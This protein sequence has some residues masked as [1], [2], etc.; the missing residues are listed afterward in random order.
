MKSQI[1]IAL[2]IVPMLLS[3]TTAFNQIPSPASAYTTTKNMDKKNKTPVSTFCTGRFLIDLPAGSQLSGGNYQYAFARIEVPKTMSKDDF[4][5]EILSREIYLR[6]TKHDSGAPML[7]EITRPDNSSAILVSWNH[8]ASTVVMSIT[9]YRWVEGRSFFFTME[10]DDDHHSEGLDAMRQLLLNLRPRFND[11]IPT[12]PGYCFEGGF[13]ANPEWENEEAGIDIDI[14]GHPDAFVSV[15]FYPL[16]MS[17][18]DK[19]LLT[20]MS[21]AIQS[22]GR[23]ATA[24]RVLRKGERQVG[25]YKGQEFLVSA[26]NSGGMRTYKR[27][28]A[29]FEG[30]GQVV[31]GR[32]AAECTAVMANEPGPLELLPT[33]QYKTWT[34]GDERHWLRISAVGIGQ[35]GMPEER[36]SFLGEGDP[37]SNI[38]LNNSAVWWKLIREDLIDPAGKEDRERAK[39]EGKVFSTKTRPAPDFDRFARTMKLARSFHQ[40]IEDRYHPNTYAYYAA[41]QHQLAWNEINWNCR[42][43]VPGDPR[44]ARLVADDLNGMMELRFGESHHRYCILQDGTGP[45]DGT[46]PAESG[47]APKPHV[48]QLFK[49]E[50]KRK[51]HESYDHQFSY[52]APISQ[53]VTLYSIIR[54]VSSSKLVAKAFEESGS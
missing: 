32:N 5:K 20:R 13:I 25:P 53:A 39:K 10:V 15:W 27:I 22:L 28:R 29:G 52:K 33:A 4:E 37:Y 36:E 17:K 44:K 14:A 24:V 19:P 43:E 3:A 40:Q 45:G 50:G 35:R 11:D 9:G 46:V 49:H 6:T 2:I 12:E 7:I 16:S 54:I 31:L 1:L 34:N 26:P 21:S 42:P 51:G 18:H 38:C 41:D 8:D 30:A 48:V 47:A 23:L